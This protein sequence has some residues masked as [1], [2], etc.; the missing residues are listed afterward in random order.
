MANEKKEHPGRG[1]YDQEMVNRIRALYKIHRST[2]TVAK[3]LGIDRQTVTKYIG[4]DIGK[5]GRRRGRPYPNSFYGKLS[6]WM[7]EHPEQTLPT[8][9]RSIM[10]IT[11]CSSGQVRGLL[12]RLRT[13]FKDDV[14]SLPDLRKLPGGFNI[15][16]ERVLFS[17]IERYSIT[18]A[19]LSRQIEVKAIIGGRERIFRLGI[20]K[21]LELAWRAGNVE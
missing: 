2:Y 9:A 4:K 5:P 11:G 7:K 16:S 14:R 8:D 3:R 12:Y 20:D 17:S 1:G 13:R 19:P 6:Q 18:G 10:E 15:E 21:L